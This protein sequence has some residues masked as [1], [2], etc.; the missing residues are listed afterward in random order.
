MSEEKY[1]IWNNKKID[2][3]LCIKA[4]GFHTV[5][6]GKMKRKTMNC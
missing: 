5:Y 2:I 1:S 4:L 3:P 6:I